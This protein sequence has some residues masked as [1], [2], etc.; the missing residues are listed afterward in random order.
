MQAA[1][2]DLV[3]YSV[4][5]SSSDSK[6]GSVS[7]HISS[8]TE[9]DALDAA[10]ERDTSS[11]GSKLGYRKQATPLALGAVDSCVYST[12]GPS[13]GAAQRVAKGVVGGDTAHTVHDGATGGAQHMPVT[14]TTTEEDIDRDANLIGSFEAQLYLSTLKLE[15]MAQQRVNHQ[16]EL[17]KCQNELKQCQEALQYTRLQ[18]EACQREQGHLQDQC[19]IVV[20]A[21][22]A[23][24][25]HLTDSDAHELEDNRRLVRKSAM[26]CKFDSDTH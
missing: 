9:C 12:P 8:S 17:V 4:H 6:G 16:R 15:K 13:G 25:A 20:Q 3:H 11:V 22:E 2:D 24:Q 7:P 18:L 14:H 19:A 21:L 26:N 23:V 10:I 1:A 5:R